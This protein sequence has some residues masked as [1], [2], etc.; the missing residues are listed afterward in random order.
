MNVSL[1][2]SQNVG[3]NGLLGFIGVGFGQKSNVKATRNVNQNVTKS[4]GQS[5]VYSNDIA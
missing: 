3:L 5:K 1:K 2:F 4:D